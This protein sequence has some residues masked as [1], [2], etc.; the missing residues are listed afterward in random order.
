MLLEEEK[1]KQKAWDHLS[2]CTGQ[3]P[4]GVFETSTKEESWQIDVCREAGITIARK[5]WRKL[6]ISIWRRQKGKYKICLQKTSQGLFC[7][8]L[9]GPRNRWKSHEGN[10]CLD[11]RKNFWVLSDKW[12]WN[13]LPFWRAKYLTTE[14]YK[15]RLQN[16]GWLIY[17]DSWT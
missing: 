10:P 8:C 2:R 7:V 13:G 17:L 11:K 5:P 12:Q 3:A 9:Q 6:E 14:S 16:G 15:W 4:R 1:R